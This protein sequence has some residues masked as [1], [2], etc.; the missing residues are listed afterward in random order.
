MGTISSNPKSKRGQNLA[1]WLR[2]DIR[3]LTPKYGPAQAEKM[4][5]LL[6]LLESRPGV[7]NV[8]DTAESNMG[9]LFGD[10]DDD[11]PVMALFRSHDNELIDH[12]PISYDATEADKRAA[13]ATMVKN[14]LPMI[15]RV[16]AQMRRVR[17]GFFQS[18]IVLRANPPKLPGARY[19]GIG[20]PGMRDEIQLSI[21]KTVSRDGGRDVHVTIIPGVNP[22]RRVIVR[23]DKNFVI[24]SMPMS[25][26][27]VVRREIE[28]LIADLRRRRTTRSNPAVACSASPKRD[29]Y[30]AA[31]V[32]H[33]GE[34]VQNGGCW[35]AK[36]V[37]SYVGKGESGKR[38]VI[39]KKAVR[40][41][42][43]RTP[44]FVKGARA[45]KAR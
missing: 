15:R 12:E 45:R 44:K 24:T 27:S 16:D 18:D 4:A 20:R 5:R 13:V 41:K 25:E 36:G 39:A 6:A 1:S 17:G 33:K 43:S 9:T 21:T 31:K 19:I 40:Q 8:L 38:R 3:L 35:D 37:P 2:H 29:R 28:A 42:A 34:W 7:G 22:I 23:T 10:P 26:S 11:M 14:N 32:M 30:R